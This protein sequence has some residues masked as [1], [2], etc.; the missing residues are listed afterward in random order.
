LLN[1]EDFEKNQEIL[2]N[3][4]NLDNIK[5]WFDIILVKKHRREIFY[6]L[7][8]CNFL[9]NFSKKTEQNAKKL[10]YK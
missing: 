7:F 10:L 4:V 2:N 5:I 3:F 8:F 9:K 1:N 6:V